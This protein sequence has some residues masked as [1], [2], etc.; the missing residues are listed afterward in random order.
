MYSRECMLVILS[1]LAK[2]LRDR[3]NKAL[4]TEFL[5]LRRAINHV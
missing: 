2:H 1:S 4:L 5:D 3:L